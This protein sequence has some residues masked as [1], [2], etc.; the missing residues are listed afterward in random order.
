MV[1][2][3]MQSQKKEIIS[4]KKIAKDK[5]L[6][7]SKPKKSVESKEPKI[8]KQ[9]KKNKREFKLFKK[10]VIKW[11]TIV[12][13][14]LIITLVLFYFLGLKIRFLI[15]DELYLS[16]SPLTKSYDVLYS[17][18]PLIEFRVS[19]DTAFTCKV[20]CTYELIDIGEGKVIYTNSTVGE[21]SHVESFTLPIN[22]RGSGQKIFNYKV[23]CNNIN[24]RTCSTEEKKYYKESVVTVNYDI[25]PTEQL[26]KDELAISLAKV[27]SDSQLMNVLVAETG[28]LIDQL[29]YNSNG[30]VTSDEN[31]FWSEQKDLEQELSSQL[32]VKDILIDM[33]DR[34]EY[35]ALNDVYGEE[36]EDFAKFL[37]VIQKNK[38]LVVIRINDFNFVLETLNDIAL[39]DSELSE[40]HGFYSRYDDFNS[41]GDVLQFRIDFQRV[42]NLVLNQGFKSFKDLKNQSLELEL[43]KNM[44]LSK[45]AKD[46]SEAVIEGNNRLNR[47]NSVISLMQTNNIDITKSTNSDLSAVCS[48]LSLF[49]PIMKTFNQTARNKLI[50]LYP[51][52]QNST[53][54]DSAIEEYLDY[55]IQIV[56]G[57][58]IEFTLDVDKYSNVTTDYPINISGNIVSVYDITTISNE[59]FSKITPLIFEK[60]FN[61]YEAHCTNFLFNFSLDTDLTKVNE[62]KMASF[63][64]VPVGT[65]VPETLNSNNPECCAFGKCSDCCSFDTCQENYP[66]ILLHGHA[67]SIGNTPENTHLR[68]SKM[69]ELLEG[70]GYINAG[71]IGSEG[72]YALSAGELG[73]VPAPISIRASYYY[74]ATSVGFGKYDLITQK[75]DGI[76]NY[77]IRLKDQIE[78]VKKLTG[79]TKVDI[80]AHSMGGLV[81]RSY[82]DLF[83]TDDVNKVILLGTPNKGITGRVRQLCSVVGAKKECEDMYSDSPFMANLNDNQEVL[84]DVD[85]YTI[86]ANGCIVGGL[87]GDG[88]VF[89]KD[90]PL[91]FTKNYEINGSC[92]DILDTN[93]HVRFIDPELYPETFQLIRQ[94][95]LA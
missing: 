66:L 68:F 7:E 30:L 1:K 31:Y 83:G 32:E 51:F 15:Q 29:N 62:L 84:Q 9:V 43:Q 58:D 89:S 94:I 46:Y 90:V 10:K 76:E 34:E 44:L 70:D 80:L 23:T 61:G 11:S 92:T 12:L 77:A 78:L 72:I 27:L 22:T 65:Y 50:E 56:N 67:I 21:N 71:Q 73:R 53:L 49:S 40:V 88:I 82:L 8:S 93:L 75:T 19:V 95:L 60:F 81:V 42:H 37:D 26:M 86:R 41:A 55:L 57:R 25:S 38:A 3:K 4:S 13:I 45:Y 5:K 36:K 85:S 48:K 2:T 28:L 74:F 20:A 24:S 87:D 69:Q 17:E 59:D 18:E 63:I 14:A 79:K 16:V 39:L 35:Y 47:L 91:N 33:W 6:K 54:L 52:L 64:G